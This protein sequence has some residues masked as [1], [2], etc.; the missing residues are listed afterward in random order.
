MARGTWLSMFE[1]LK[2]LYENMSDEMSGRIDEIKA[3]IGEN[4][5]LSDALVR[6]FDLK[7]VTSRVIA[8]SNNIINTSPQVMQTSLYEI[9]A[10]LNESSSDRL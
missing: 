10:L 4:P 2:T 5:V 1:E 6:V 9:H 7:K 8:L 3:E